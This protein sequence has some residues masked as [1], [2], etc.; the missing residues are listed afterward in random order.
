MSKLTPLTELEGQDL[1]DLLGEAE[2]TRETLIQAQ[3]AAEVARSQFDRRYRELRI[4]HGA[5]NNEHW[6]ASANCWVQMQ[7]PP[8]GSPPGTPPRM[9]PLDD[10][11]GPPAAPKARPLFPVEDAP[12][13]EPRA[14]ALTEALKE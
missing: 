1:M 9:V 5:K 3:A 10:A 4:K 11:E 7:P 13:D 8:P 2:R 14:K 6:D 12:Q